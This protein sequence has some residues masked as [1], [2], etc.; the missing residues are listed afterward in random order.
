MFQFAASTHNPALGAAAF[1]LQ[2]LGNITLMA[3]L[4]LL[5]THVGGGRLRRGLAASPYRP[6][7][8]SAASLIVSGTHLT[9]CWCVR[10]PSFFGIGWWPTV[11]WS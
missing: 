8:F 3:A 1:A 9:T 6:A 4:Y 5:V 2:I 10:V 7:R 11:P